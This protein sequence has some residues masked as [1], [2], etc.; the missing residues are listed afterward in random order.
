MGAQLEIEADLRGRRVGPIVS[1]ATDEVSW[2]YVEWKK[3]SR[4]HSKGLSPIFFSCRIGDLIGDQC[5]RPNEDRSCR[6]GPG[7]KCPH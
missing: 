1:G 2:E 6:A 5:A 4:G 7:R 3:C